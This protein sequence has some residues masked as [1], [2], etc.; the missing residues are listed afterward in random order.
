[1]A[2]LNIHKGFYR[3]FLRKASIFTSFKKEELRTLRKLSS[4]FFRLILF[5]RAEDWYLFSLLFLFRQNDGFLF[6]GSEGFF[7][8]SSGYT[9]SRY[10]TNRDLGSP[11]QGN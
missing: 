5:L 4:I 10:L 3:L 11:S 1:M 8:H 6:L 7:S 9:N 2:F